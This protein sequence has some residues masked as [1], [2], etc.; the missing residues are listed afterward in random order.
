MISDEEL[1]DNAVKTYFELKKTFDNPEDI[2]IE[3]ADS[4]KNRKGKK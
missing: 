1:I 2:F 4:I 3:L